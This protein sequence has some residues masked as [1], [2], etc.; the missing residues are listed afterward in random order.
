M[1]LTFSV[2][3]LAIRSKGLIKSGSIKRSFLPGSCLGKTKSDGSLLEVL[4]TD[5][6]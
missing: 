5:V 1:R 4:S 6:N 3:T 2:D